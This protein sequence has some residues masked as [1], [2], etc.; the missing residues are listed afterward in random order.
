MADKPLFI[1]PN[2]TA[3]PRIRRRPGFGSPNYHYPDV[4]RQK[5]RLTPQ[6][7]TMLQAFVTDTETGIE[8]ECALVIETI[9]EI[10]DFAR[11]V[12]AIPGLEWLAEID[13]DEIEPDEDL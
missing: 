1:F 11:A 8:P 3:A 6:F 7:Q 12:R 13:M 5:D 2:P 9:G 4:N 10:E